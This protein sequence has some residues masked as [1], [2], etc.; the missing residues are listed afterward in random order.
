[1]T[2]RAW[3]KWQRERDKIRVKASTVG[4]C[5]NEI[6]LAL[7]SPFIRLP[8]PS[9]PI[10][11]GELYS[12]IH[13]YAEEQEKKW[14]SAQKLAWV[15][16]KTLLWWLSFFLSTVLQLLA[17]LW[18]VAPRILS[19]YWTVFLPQEHSSTQSEAVK[20]AKLPWNCCFNRFAETIK[21]C[22]THSNRFNNNPLLRKAFTLDFTKSC[23]STQ[24]LL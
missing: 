24:S 3:M 13:F 7:W 21:L 22:E 14:C 19:R 5:T 10:T 1:M 15:K 9:N 20:V 12:F 4:S 23:T 6:T 18:I 2:H 16:K 11:C 8:L 17:P